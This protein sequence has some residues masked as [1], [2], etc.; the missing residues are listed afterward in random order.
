MKTSR[1][2][3]AV[4]ALVISGTCSAD[5]VVCEYVPGQKVTLDTDTDKY[6]YW[7]VSDFV[8]MTY[9]EQVS[10]IAGLDTYGNI[11]G[12]W[13]MATAEDIAELW[14]YDGWSLLASFDPT[15]TVTTTLIEIQARYDGAG[16][17]G[18]HYMLSTWWP[19]SLPQPVKT[20]LP[21]DELSDTAT[22]D[23]REFP[24][25]A[26][27]VGEGPVIPAPGAILL[28]TIGAGLVG[29]LRR[30]RAL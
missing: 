27:V 13:H 10:A 18:S 4:V 25:G 2:L 29:W 9:D 1:T 15:L 23:A 8:D 16:S 12:G 19:I 20:S 24:V 6:W 22:S 26:F 28:G 7:G 17:D 14:Q 5:L 30:R 21:G 3:C 11:A